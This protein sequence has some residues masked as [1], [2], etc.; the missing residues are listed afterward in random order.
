MHFFQFLQQLFGA[1]FHNGSTPIVRTYQLKSQHLG[2][3][4]EIDVYRPAVFPFQQMQL[5]LFNDGQ[6]LR[7]MDTTTTLGNLYTKKQLPPTLVVGLI[8]ADRLR[9]Y[10]TSERPDYQGRGDMARAQ[11]LF[12]TTELLPWL[13]K[14]YSLWASPQYRSFAGFSLGGLNAFD[15][16]WR[17]PQ[18]FSTV[19]VFSGALWWRSAP[20]KPEDPDADRIIHTYVAQSATA[21]QNFRAWLMA[22]TN[23]ETDDRN[24]NGIID[25]IDDSLQLCSLLEHKGLQKP[26]QLHY[27]EVENGQHHPDTWKTV[28]ADYLRWWGGKNR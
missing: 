9:E 16:V 10:G 7:R 21:P 19:G 12:V 2:R 26:H 3:K 28:L 18:H 4:V 13:E 20:F 1:M 11:E 15:L 27:V 24:H 23:D 6:D 17:N 22:G 8:A 25:A 5:A 14:R